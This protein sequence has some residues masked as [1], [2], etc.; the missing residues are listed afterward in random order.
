MTFSLDAGCFTTRNPGPILAS[1][2]MRCHASNPAKIH[3]PRSNILSCI[4][5]SFSPLIPLR[6]SDA[7]PTTARS[8]GVGSN[9][10]L[11]MSASWFARLF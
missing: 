3:R 8:R 4:I 1:K 5:P 7:F 11:P 9:A 2:R 10:A 6:V